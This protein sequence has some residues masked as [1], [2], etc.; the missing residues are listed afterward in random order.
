MG[1]IGI[2]NFYVTQ[3]IYIFIYLTF[4]A[5]YKQ[6]YIY[7]FFLRFNSKYLLPNQVS[8]M[9]P[10]YIVNKII[11]SDGGSYVFRCPPSFSFYGVI[12]GP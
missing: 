7:S 1:A 2:V 8:H 5:G 4:L 11:K 9:F 10:K 12:I 6:N 3:K